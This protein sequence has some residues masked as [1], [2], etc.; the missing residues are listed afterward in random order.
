MLHIQRLT[1]G[2]FTVSFTKSIITSAKPIALRGGRMRK[3]GGQ[4]VSFAPH[5]SDL[6]SGASRMALGGVLILSGVAALSPSS[7][8]AEPVSQK[9]EGTTTIICSGPASPSGDDIRIALEVFE[10]TTVTTAPGFGIDTSERSGAAIAINAYADANVSFT[11]ANSSDISGQA[12]GVIIINHYDGDISI[13]TNGSVMGSGDTYSAALLAYSSSDGDISIT[14]TGLVAAA[15]G[16]VAVQTGSGNITVENDGA[17]LGNTAIHALHSGT[18]SITVTTGEDS[19]TVSADS[20]D[21]SGGN[22]INAWHYGAGAVEPSSTDEALV[23]VRIT[24]AAGGQILASGEYGD[25]INAWAE[26]TGDIIINNA[27][28]LIAEDYGIT[29]N[30]A[31]ASGNAANV[32][33]TNSG[34]IDRTRV[35]INAASSSDGIVAIHNSGQVISKEQ[36]IRGW[37]VGQGSLDISNAGSLTSEGEFGVSAYANG[38]SLIGITNS[39]SVNITR[40]EI[41]EELWTAALHTQNDGDG[42]TS[43]TNTGTITANLIG[44]ADTDAELGEFGHELSISDIAVDSAGINALGYGNG[45]VTVVNGLNSGTLLNAALADEVQEFSAQIITSA[46]ADMSALL[47]S[48]RDAEIWGFNGV[49]SSVGV[50][51]VQTGDALVD[52]TN[53]GLI[54]STA[55][56]TGNLTVNAWDLYVNASNTAA[57][58]AGVAALHQGN[59]NLNITN[60]GDIVGLASTSLNRNFSAL[61]RASLFEDDDSGNDTIQSA[62]V[63][64]G[65]TVGHFGD[66]DIVIT[67]HGNT[68][69]EA[70]NSGDVSINAYGIGGDYGMLTVN[71]GAIGVAAHHSGTGAIT[72]TNDGSIHSTATNNGTLSLQADEWVEDA[73]G[74]STATAVGIKAVHIGNGSITIHNSGDIETVA[75]IRNP[76]SISAYDI[77]NSG[78][79]TDAT[80]IGIQAELS[81]HYQEGDITITN[82]G[83][84]KASA[85]WVLDELDMLNNR[86][87]F[88]AW[89]Y[90]TAAGISANHASTGNI[91]ITNDG[92]ISAYGVRADGVSATHSGY[93]NINI[94]NNDEIYGSDDG[95]SAEHYSRGNISIT[96]NGQI[97]AD[98][99]AIYAYHDGR[100]DIIVTNNAVLTS[101]DDEGIDA[102]HEGK[103]SISITNLGEIV[104]D[105]HGIEASHYG[106]GSIF[107]TNAGTIDARDNGISAEHDGRGNISI[108]NT[109]TGIID[110]RDNG[111]D[112][113]HYGRGNVTIANAGTI[114]ANEYGINVGHNGR[115]EVVIVNTGTIDAGY[116]GIYAYK[117]GKGDVQVANAQGA[118]INAGDFGVYVDKSGKG[119][120]RAENAGSIT[121]GWD[122]LRVNHYGKGAATVVNTGTLTAG[123]NAIDASHSGRGNIDITTTGNIVSGEAND[124]DSYAAI[125]ASH[126]GRGDISITTAG[127]VKGSYSAI[128]AYA[129]NGAI[130]ITNNGSLANLSGESSDLVIFAGPS[131]DDSNGSVTITNNGIITGA[132][133]TDTDYYGYYEPNG[134]SFDDT[135]TN[136]G[137]WNTE[138]AVNRFGAGT[139]ILTNVGTI[140]AANAYFLGLDS[141]VNN[142][143]LSL[144][145]TAATDWLIT[146]GSLT[147]NADSQVVLDISGYNADNI[148]AYG[149]LEIDGGSLIVNQVGPRAKPGIFY[150]LDGTTRSGEFATTNLANTAFLDLNLNYTETGVELEIEQVRQFSDLAL[151]PNQRGISAAL[152][153]IEVSLQPD[154]G[155][156]PMMML[157]DIDLP[158]DNVMLD[159]ILYLPTEAAVADALNQLSGESHAALRSTLADDSRLPRNAILNR[160]QTREGSAVW[161][162]LFYGA[163]NLDQAKNRA[164]SGSKRDAWGFILGVDAAVSENVTFGFAGS[165]INHE[166]DQ[167]ARGSKLD[168]ETVNLLAYVG[169]EAGKARFKLGAGYAWGD[170]NTSRSVNF[171]RFSDRLTANYDASLIQAF[172]ELGYRLPL[173]G[174]YVEPMVNVIYV[175]TTTDAFTEKG[176]L[177]ALTAEKRSESTTLSTL[178]ARFSTAQ[179]GIFSINGM[180]GWQ[181]GFGSLTPTNIMTFEGSD[182]FTIQGAPQSRN[183]AVASLEAKFD[184]NDKTSISLGYDGV[185][186]NVSQD[187]AAK[188]AVRVKF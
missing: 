145:N 103:G 104:A 72:I 3:R 153:S 57:M 70:V 151:T 111:I 164:T 168:A 4:V 66:G 29:A 110:A 132:I 8:M 92:E 44:R 78:A 17:V 118:V 37:H 94:I 129:A 155:R 137:V 15:T 60:S 49:A 152:E 101:Y 97:V 147:L 121:S 36:A 34:D 144:A 149:H 154:L 166:S 113:E 112:V 185:L 27:A 167:Q 43:I 19:L 134:T 126:T 20:D 93:G 188:V 35:G 58:S 119:E 18:G 50:R 165:V 10:D 174:G 160:M 183:A 74:Q 11:D 91:N 46:T 28:T 26:G 102:L 64:Y 131:H 105:D 179:T 107:V 7:A 148:Y 139:D 187:H 186:G 30:N 38:G 88:Y 108:S 86:Q 122:A 170:I 53:N 182:S 79:E 157:M 33:I 31:A 116:D 69:S 41:G 99:D 100:G 114:D 169:A 177:A 128:S 32:S 163:G 45:A 173:G 24:T 67:N 106:K 180:A 181:H 125:F 138:N 52:V 161:G 143:T 127:S 48:D 59:A 130:E 156:A 2:I 5:F 73:Y 42:T 96:N 117:D 109:A 68:T 87:G 133:V 184:V 14:N 176:G 55:A 83:T 158:E 136:N 80:S 115:G 51:V 62:T 159:E 22:A 54:E 150:L 82:A 171:G 172:A 135:I 120:A 124:Y 25:A 39:G 6:L 23:A 75:T 98:D 77:Y 140:N 85:E 56:V 47:I 123:A 71:T 1:R 142:G 21:I 175:D 162:E 146:T 63:A 76:I 12:G 90:S 13:T 61:D 81:G 84:I 65:I 178:G 9:C 16:I 40:N 95:I 89:D 141:F